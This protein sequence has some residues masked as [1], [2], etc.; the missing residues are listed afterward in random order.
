MTKTIK[1]NYCIGDIDGA[2]GSL[3]SS[4]IPAEDPRYARHRIIMKEF[5]EIMKESREPTGKL[6]ITIG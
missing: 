1:I 3:V 4:N 6:E 2:P 5:T